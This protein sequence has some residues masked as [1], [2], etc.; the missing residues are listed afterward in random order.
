MRTLNVT[1]FFVFAMADQGVEMDYVFTSVIHDRYIKLSNGWE[2]TPGRGLHIFQKAESKY[3][4]M[5]TY[6]QTLRPCQE[7]KIEIKKV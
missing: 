6:D 2:I 3:Y 4:G 1:D 7:C 5:G